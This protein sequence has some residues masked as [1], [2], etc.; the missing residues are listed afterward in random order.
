MAHSNE[1]LSSLSGPIVAHQVPEDSVL[2]SD[3]SSSTASHPQA[4]INNALLSF[5]TI[6]RFLIP[7]QSLCGNIFTLNSPPLS[8]AHQPLLLLSLPT[9]LTSTHYQRNEFIFTFTL[10][11]DPAADIP[12]YK[13]VLRKLTSLI[14]S[15]EEQSHFLS[16]DYSPP[17]SG[18]IYSLCEM[19]MEDLNN[20]AECMIPIPTDDASA[21][22]ASLNTLNIKLFPTLASPP[23]IQA[24]YVPLFVVRIETLIDENWDITMQRIIPFIN[25]VN[26]VKRIAGLADADL[27][28]TRKCIKH[29][30]YYGCV[31]LLDIF[32]FNA[33]YA[34]TNEFG[35]M[36]AK[37]EVMQKECARYCN[38]KF[39]EVRNIA[40]EA[41]V[42]ERRL[43]EEVWPFM[44]NDEALD[45]VS[46]VQLF[47]NLSQ[48]LTVR[49]WYAQNAEMLANV[50]V[51]RFVTFGVIKGFLYRIHRY[52][53]KST[54][55]GK[56]GEL[57]APN[58]IKSRRRKAQ[59]DDSD[60]EVEQDIHS[61]LEP[62]L[63]GTHCFDEICTELE[64]SERELVE[65]LS[66]RELGEVIT[67]CR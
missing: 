21:E 43:N 49:E 45:G 28:L 47:A 42:D 59:N 53:I 4:Q 20:Y 3:L 2:T 29:L 55:G 67:I 7:R 58:G 33:I 26:S 23:K 60:D 63:D 5:R 8:P 25:G 34:P 36:I 12:S 61:K 37:D 22:Q 48:G 17:N 32:S 30:V 1:Q 16:N 66:S 54:K 14:T 31:L 35:N 18:K 38:L 56:L 41:V 50:D 15:L 10:A 44:A 9:C 65:R 24:W 52:A 64:I 13:S 40:E 62:Y 19:L 51:R 57:N 27:K 39:S 6:S 11:L 46:V